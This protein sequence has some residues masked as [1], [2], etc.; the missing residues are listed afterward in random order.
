MTDKASKLAWRVLRVDL[1]SGAITVE[2]Q[3]EKFIRRH[4][5]GQGVAAWYLNREVPPGVEPFDPG[6]RL[7][8]TGGLLT[9]LKFP[10]AGRGSVAARSPLT[11]G[12]GCA[13]FGG[14]FSAELRHAGWDTLIVQGRAPEPVYLHI[15]DDQVEIRPAAALWGLETGPAQA[16]ILAEVGDP[17]TRVAC[18]GPAGENRVRYAAVIADLRH[19][20][21]RTG[22]GAVMGGKNL[23]AV[24]VRGHGEVGARDPERVE[25]VRR[26]LTDELAT[27]VYG[28]FFGANGTAG[29][30]SVQN[31]MSV[32]PTQNFRAGSFAEARAISGE[33]LNAKYLASRGACYACPLACKRVVK[34]EVADPRYGG[35]EYE[36]MAA[37]GS[38]LGVNDLAAVCRAHER[39]NALGVDS[40]SA[41]VCI[42][43]AM[44]GAEKGVLDATAGAPTWG[45]AAGALALLEDIA[46][47]RGASAG[48]DPA[49]DHPRL[50][51]LLAEGVKRAAAEIGRGSEEWAMQVHGQEL[52]MHEPKG[53]WGVGLGYVASVT[54]A[55]HNTAAQDT[56]FAGKG[57]PVDLITTVG[58]DEPVPPLDLGPRKVRAY[59]QLANFSALVNCLVLCN[60]VTAPTTGLNLTA[61]REVVA[62]VTGWD[63]SDWE[64][65]AAGERATVL[66][67]C[68]NVRHGAFG[69]DRL[70]ARLHVPFEAGML[71][72]KTVTPEE[73][74]R[75][76][77]LY[78]E[79]MGYDERG[80]PRPGRLVQLQL[81]WLAGEIGHHS[82]RG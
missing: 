44:E 59:A 27:S 70:P 43:F 24:A 33:E 46:H 49:L 22:L 80:V 73:F 14:Y 48:L 41:G 8:F 31:A 54:G 62:G 29:G 1:G 23:K 36:T 71:R 81:D 50:G 56:L 55:D 16:A 64:L 68:F 57:R 28:K 20:A 4:L 76:V 19:A 77:A 26:A 75:A 34:A 53:K 79:M 66:A 6:N 11:G 39:C 63:V 42:A 30:L 78:Y 38:L 13:E 3:G 5:G 45:D 72:G 37:F 9:G 67:R 2:E 82:L 10:G 61:L 52:P 35:P 18:I 51:D 32:L 65:L 40:I 74:A 25:R 15:V 7:I 12:F 69:D 60:F 58:V 17:K 21:G 47:R